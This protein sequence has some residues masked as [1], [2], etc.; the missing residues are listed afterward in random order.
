MNARRLPDYDEGDL[1]LWLDLPDENA[2]RVL[3]RDMA[4][5]CGLVATERRWFADRLVVRARSVRLEPTGEP[6]AARI[7]DLEVI[8]DGDAHAGDA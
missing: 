7:H 6:V 1:D 3:V 8:D 5:G 2:L 4:A